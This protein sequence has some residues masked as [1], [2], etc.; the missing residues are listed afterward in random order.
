MKF[1]AKPLFI[2]LAF[3]II[4]N[5]IIGLKTPLTYRKDS[6]RAEVCREMSIN[7]NWWNPTL[8]GEPFYTKPP[9][10]YWLG[11]SIFIISGH[12]HPQLIRLIHILS[13]IF[14][15]GF[16]MYFFRHRLTKIQQA[17]MS[18][19][20]FS[21]Y[22]FQ[23]H[24]FSADLDMLM[25][26]CCSVSF[27]CLSG[28]IQD[29]K[30]SHLI[31]GLIAFGFAL[32]VKG[33]ISILFTIFPVAVWIVFF[34]KWSFLKKIDWFTALL[35]SGLCMI[36]WALYTFRDVALTTMINEN[37][38]PS[39]KL[40]AFP[41]LF[42]YFWNL[43]ACTLPWSIFLLFFCK[44][45]WKKYSLY[46]IQIL[47]ALFVMGLFPKHDIRYLLPV[48]PTIAVLFSFFYPQ[49]Q[50]IASKL[51][52]FKI[53]SLL[54]YLIYIF[55]AAIIFYALYIFNPY[56]GILFL[57]IGLI[58]VAFWLYILPKSFFCNHVVGLFFIFLSCNFILSIHGGGRM[59]QQFFELVKAKYPSE[60]IYS[61]E[62]LNWGASVQL[63]RVILRVE[64]HNLLQ[65]LQEKKEILLLIMT[66][67][68]KNKLSLPPY[69]HKVELSLRVN[70][71]FHHV[72]MNQFPFNLIP[73][74]DFQ[75][76]RIYLNTP[77]DI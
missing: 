71:Y 4:S 35:M 36:P 77:Q 8:L 29:F 18:L 32:L 33:P 55:L 62:V 47:S 13:S 24:M 51:R 63:D 39:S 17:I 72:P 61:Y 16:L 23:L 20:L 65:L 58:F 54:F 27:F 5:S 53:T 37:G 21:M 14:L 40:G 28:Y 44:E 59:R 68:T 49:F 66:D 57:G 10:F 19:S 3:F 60:A 45:V 9:L 42:Y 74:G 15:M 64:Q 38:G 41:S 43:L 30:K 34:K 48:F 25:T 67:E 2:F 69:P 76:I 52:L 46:F 75:L 50:E 70:D 56:Y 11:T 12:D 26:L 22:M 1:L 7:R 6:R 31:F 73:R